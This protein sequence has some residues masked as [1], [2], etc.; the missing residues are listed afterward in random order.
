MKNALR[1]ANVVE[2]AAMVEKVKLTVNLTDED[3]QALKADAESRGISVTE[4]LRRAI[5]LYKVAGK[6]GTEVIVREAP[7]GP[8]SRIVM[9]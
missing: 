6:K 9:P 8:S 1:T 2:A 3:M 4:A 7:D 5:A